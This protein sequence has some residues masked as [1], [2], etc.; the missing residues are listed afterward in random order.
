MRISRLASRAAALLLT[1]PAFGCSEGQ[2]PSTTMLSIKLTDAPATLT[3]ATVTISEVYLQGAGG[4]VQ[5]SNTPTTVNLL[6]LQNATLDLV[7]DVEV[8]AGTYAQLRIVVTGAYVELADGTIYASSPTYAGL[9][10]GATVTGGL[11]LPSYA[12]TGIKVLLANDALVLTEP[13]KIVVID[14][15]A[16]Q[17]F[18]QAAGQSGR[19][20]MTPVIREAQISAAAATT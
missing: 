2:G 5:L 12:Q 4:R 17:S 3:A 1:L 16:A 6:D 20:V 7:K 8:P 14:F 9:P 15:D 18:G 11:Q 10:S 13:E 19:W